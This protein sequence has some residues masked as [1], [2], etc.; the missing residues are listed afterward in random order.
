M[1]PPDPKTWLVVASHPVVGVAATLIA[2][3][4]AL[5]I[6]RRCR[7]NPI[8]NPTLLAILMLA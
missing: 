7:G 8:T 6:N 3:S 2:Y 1:L 4:I 5:R